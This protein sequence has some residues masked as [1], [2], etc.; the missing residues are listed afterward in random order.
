MDGKIAVIARGGAQY[1]EK[2]LIAQMLGA[3]GVIVGN[4][5]YD[6]S[7]IAMDAGTKGLQHLIN[8]PAIMIS[9]MDYNALMDYLADN[10]SGLYAVMEEGNPGCPVRKWAT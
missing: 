3:V 10:P 4:T 6:D 1:V 2:I 5:A 8:I 9:S 7:L